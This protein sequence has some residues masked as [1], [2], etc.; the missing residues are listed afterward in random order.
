MS[1]ENARPCSAVAHQQAE[2][3]PAELQ[4]REPALTLEGQLTTEMHNGFAVPLIE[5]V[6]LAQLLAYGL[7]AGQRD[8]R[9]GWNMGRVRITIERLRE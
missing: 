6:E 9:F 7:K 1:A 4:R 5:D 2:P 8:S 3:L